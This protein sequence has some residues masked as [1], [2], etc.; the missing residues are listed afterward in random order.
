ML[1]MILNLLPLLA[2]VSLILVFRYLDKDNRSIEGA[3][4]YIDNAKSQFDKYFQDNSKKIQ[5]AEIELETK[6]SVAI[7]A[8][9]RLESIQEEVVTKADSFQGNIDSISTMEKQLSQYSEV[10]NDLIEM[11]A[12]VEENLQRLQTESRFLDKTTKKITSQKSLLDSLENR[13][14]NIISDF[15]NE[16]LAQL[17]QVSKDLQEKLKSLSEQLETQTKQNLFSNQELLSEIEKTYTTAVDGAKNKAKALETSVISS[18][19]QELE[20]NLEKLKSSSE[21]QIKEYEAAIADYDVFLEKSKDAVTLG[22][23]GYCHF[24]LENLEAALEDLNLCIELKDDYAWAYYTRG[25]ILQELEKF[26]EAREDY[27]K[28]N[29]LMD[30]EK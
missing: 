14:P 9:K 1:E 16:N 13:I 19:K 23:R 15:K 26:E 21:A 27:E 11:T 12:N 4:R 20:E 29:S 3:K 28:A 17:D 22:N 10:L 25:K 6:Q 5:D 7:A 24:K 2:S 18:M 8:I 30:T